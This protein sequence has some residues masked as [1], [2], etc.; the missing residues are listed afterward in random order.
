MKLEAC[1]KHN[2]FFIRV[3]TI[4]NIEYKKIKIHFD[5][6]K[7]EYDFWVD[8]D[9]E[10][11]HPIFWCE[12]TDHPLQQPYFFVKPEPVN[13]NEITCPTV[14]CFG[15]G[16]VKGS[17]FLTHRSESGCPYAL[18]NIN[19]DLLPN[20]LTSVPNLNFIKPMKKYKKEIFKSRDIISNKTKEIEIFESYKK[21]AFIFE[22]N[23]KVDNI[24]ENDLNSRID[25]ND[26]TRKAKN[27][28][29]K[30]GRPKKSIL[31]KQVENNFKLTKKKKLNK[32]HSDLVKMQVDENKSKKFQFF[33]CR[34]KIATFCV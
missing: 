8:V 34:Q 28:S 33:Y 3:C 5:G 17:N 12:K 16:H 22:T 25:P 15:I 6:W 26:S 14:G 31:G 1:D 11:I 21:D 13:E 29:I 23:N 7:E 4:V 24:N 10:D 27:I 19:K 9:S 32:E 30:R 2:P 18:K 20:R